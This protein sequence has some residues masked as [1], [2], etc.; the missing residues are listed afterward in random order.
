MGPGIVII[1]LIYI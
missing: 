1:T